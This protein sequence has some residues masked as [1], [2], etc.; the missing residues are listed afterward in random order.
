LLGI[1]SERGP[2]GDRYQL[3]L[4]LNPQ[5]SQ[6]GTVRGNLLIRTNDLEVPSLMVP[7]AGHLLPWRRHGMG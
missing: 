7:I 3:T 4:T 6:P 2:Q 5:K 1:R